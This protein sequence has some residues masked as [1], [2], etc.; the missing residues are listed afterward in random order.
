MTKEDTAA[1]LNGLIEVCKDGEDGYNKAAGHVH[2]T[3]LRTIFEGYAK[4]R[5]QFSRV[6][7][8]E[9]ERLGRSPVDSG[10]L[11]AAV[12]RGWIGSEGDCDRR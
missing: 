4:Q 9:V 12:Y 3:E 8:A 10:T 1:H 6:L 2:N 7:Q 5:A 11:T